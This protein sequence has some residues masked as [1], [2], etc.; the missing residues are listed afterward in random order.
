MLSSEFEQEYGREPSAEEIAAELDMKPG[1][2]KDTMRIASRHVSLDAPLKAGEDNRLLDLI[3]DDDQDAP[4]EALMEDSLK[5]EIFKALDSLT[6]RE[7]AV[8]GLY[9]SLI[10]ISAPTRQAEI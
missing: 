3:E 2:V 10:H 4:D 5:E 6:E 7:A 9:L 8:I 1:D